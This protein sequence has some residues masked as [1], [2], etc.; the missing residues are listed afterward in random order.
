MGVYAQGL[1]VCEVAQAPD[2]PIQS[3]VAGSSV[4]VMCVCV[5]LYLVCLVCLVCV[6]V[7][8]CTWR[9]CVFGVLGVCVCVC[10][11][12]CVRTRA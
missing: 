12:V 5:C 6:R 1:Q 9:L 10:V 2:S 3:V 7:S 8:V 4:E 11:C